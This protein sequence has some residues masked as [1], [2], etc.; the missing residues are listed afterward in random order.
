MILSRRMPSQPTRPIPRRHLIE[1]SRG[2]CSLFGT[3][4]LERVWRRAPATEGLPDSGRSPPTTGRRCAPQFED[5]GR[6]LS[7]K[8]LGVIDPPQ[9]SCYPR[10]VV[11]GLF[12]PKSSPP[13]LWGVRVR[14]KLSGNNF[15]GGCSG[16]GVRVMGSWCRRGQIVVVGVSRV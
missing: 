1:N 3:L 10:G 14:P 12:R 8:K 4:L 11:R 5:S 16:D 2:N 13:K 6:A 9:R 15:S 7:K